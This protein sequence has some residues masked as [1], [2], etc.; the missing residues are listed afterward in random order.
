VPA[1]HP[2]RAASRNWGQILYFT[3]CTYTR[4]QD[5]AGF[6]FG[7]LGF[8]G[9]ASAAHKVVAPQTVDGFTRSSALAQ[10][11]HLSTLVQGVTTSAKGAASD[12]A[13]GVYEKGR[14]PVGNGQIFIFIGG[15]VANADPSASVANFEQTYKNATAAPA[16][17]LGGQAACAEVE[18]NGEDASM[19]VWFDNDT[20][21]AL[22]SATMTTAKLA[23]VTVTV[24]P[25]M[26]QLAK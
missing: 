16:G 15:R 26:E 14:A 12:L 22:V 10:Q 7:F 8:F 13:S 18:V 5:K 6:G 23:I 24:R 25:G 19:C 17:S 3:N 9:P 11:M 21:G 4:A 1:A 20:F 2:G